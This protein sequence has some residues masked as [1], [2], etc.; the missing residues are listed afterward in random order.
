MKKLSGIL[1][2]SLLVILNSCILQGVGEGCYQDL[3]INL[4]WLDTKPV[5]TEGKPVTVNVVPVQKGGDRETQQSDV[6]GTE[7]NVIVGEYVVIGYETAQN[8]KVDV[9]NQTVAVSSNPDG[10]A[11]EP[12]DFSAGSTIVTIE[13]GKDAPEIKLPLYKQVRKLVIQ[14]Q[15]KG[16]SEPGIQKI[17]AVFDGIAIDRHINNGFPPHDGTKRPN[18]IERGNIG[19]NFNFIEQNQYSSW[20]EGSRTLLGID[21]GGRQTIDLNIHFNDG[22]VRS[23][24]GDLTDAMNG[25]HTEDLGQDQDNPWYILLVINVGELEINIEDWNDGGTSWIIAESQ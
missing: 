13:R 24:H 7:T 4:D 2:L 20:Y 18:A 9:D 19:Y 14:L 22:A 25:F 6:R 10:E 11:N 1:L 15:V 3:F 12:G 21:G 23:L 5:T 16:L 8:V 17:E